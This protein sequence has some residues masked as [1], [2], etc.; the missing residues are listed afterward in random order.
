MDVKITVKIK[1]KEKEITL[2][3]EE[4]RELKQKLD[5]KFDT[6]GKE[7]YIPMPYPIYPQVYPPVITY[8]YDTVTSGYMQVLAG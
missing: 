7:I 6:Q 2:T 5:E 4:A 1:M 8:K 3:E